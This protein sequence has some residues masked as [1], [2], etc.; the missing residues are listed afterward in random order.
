MS[1]LSLHQKITPLNVQEEKRKFYFDS[2]YNPQFEY[3]EEV[4]L[5]EWMRY[6]PISSEFL[7]TAKRI[8]ESVIKDFGTES[9][10]LEQTEGEPLSQEEVN[11]T[12]QEYLRANGLEK[13]VIV[14]YSAK[15][16]ARTT[17]KKNVLSLRT[18]TNYRR[19]NMQSVLN[20]EIGTH[21]FRRI[22]EDAQPW[23][24]R[25]REFG[26]IDDPEESVWSGSYLET[27]EGL[28]VI[29]AN[30]SLPDKRLWVPALSYIAVYLAKEMSFAEMFK[31]LKQYTEDRDRRWILCLKAKRGLRDTSLPG[32]FSKNQLYFSGAIKVARWM[33][34]HDFAV[35]DLYLG[36]LSLDDI[37]KAKAATHLQEVR[38]PQFLKQKGMYSAAVKEIISV[39]K[40][41]H[42]MKEK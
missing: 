9:Q 39:N 33:S 2:Q 19:N 38:L 5:D 21:Y 4:S 27:E 14:Q 36:K 35:E 18:P 10:Y 15:Q 20:H 28:A 32:G 7:P 29:N 31:E 17:M 13:E 6:G 23:K 11:T 12:I 26:F 42:F 41:E 22:N 16:I 34:T 3:E 37:E 40:F 8:I 24:G 30:V 25:H 1:G